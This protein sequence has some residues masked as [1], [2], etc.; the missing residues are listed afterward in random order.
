ME[1]HPSAAIPATASWNGNGDDRY[2]K[3][4]HNFLAEVPEFFLENGTF[5]SFAS[6]PSNNWR[7]EKGKTYKMRVQIRKSMDDP[8]GQKKIARIGYLAADQTP[9]DLITD[10]GI[11]QAV[12]GSETF[13]MYDRPTAFGPPSFGARLTNNNS[14]GARGAGSTTSIH[15]GCVHSG[16]G[17]GSLYGY[18]APF[19]PAYYDGAAW[20]DLEVTPGFESPTFDELISQMTSSYLRYKGVSGADWADNVDHAGEDLGP[21]AGARM[22]DNANQISSSVNIFGKA[23]YFDPNTQEQDE[24]WIIQTKFETPMLNFIDQHLH[25]K[26]TPVAIDTNTG[27]FFASG[28]ILSRAIGMWHQYGRL[29]KGEEGVF[30]EVIDHPDVGDQG[31]PACESMAD[32]LNFSK[33]SQRLGTPADSKTIREAVVAVPFYEEDNERRFFEIGKEK[34]DFILGRNT[35]GGGAGSNAMPTS[36][37]LESMKQMVDSMQR[38]H[39]PHS[40]DFIKYSDIV[41]PFVMYIFEFEHELSREDVTDI[42]QNLPPRIGRAFD[43]EAVRL[44]L[45]P[46]E[47]SEIMQT[48]E[49]SHD[50]QPGELLNVPLKSKLQWM[51]FKVKQRAKKNYY[52]KSVQS[53]PVTQLPTPAEFATSFD[54]SGMVIGSVVTSKPSVAETLSKSPGGLLDVLAEGAIVGAVAKDTGAPTT[55]DFDITYNWPYDFFSLVELVKIDQQ[56]QFET[57][58]EYKDPFDRSTPAY[59][60]LNVTSAN[61][62]SPITFVFDPDAAQRTF[63]TSIVQLMVDQF[64]IGDN[65]ASVLQSISNELGFIDSQN[66]KPP[67]TGISGTTR[68]SSTKTFTRIFYDPSNNIVTYRLEMGVTKD[69]SGTATIYKVI[70]KTN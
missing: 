3:A 54:P 12:S 5:T 36:T 21:Q 51:V 27:S 47:T 61:Q 67:Q 39:F 64:E 9:L 66:V 52:K 63:D 59:T 6:S 29:P 17:G 53:S 24:R 46:P 43:P 31:A 69:Q 62:A 55:E 57:S 20:V 34:I 30:L 70:T 60:I 48:K 65:S 11:P 10:S 13:V 23:R 1:P 25:E 49:I 68:A 18:N 37:P 40:M 50:L 58:E 14:A 38:Y 7:F 28:S 41:K 33:D 44:N 42:W 26:L 8:T 15:G 22:N 2:K 56:V 45:N 35:G 19:T 16:F 4:M 32:A